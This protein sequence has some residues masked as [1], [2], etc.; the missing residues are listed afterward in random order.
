MKNNIPIQ[1]ILIIRRRSERELGLV[2][3]ERAL[4]RLGEKDENLTCLWLLL[5]T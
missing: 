4:T 5:Y 2:L 1:L 3:K